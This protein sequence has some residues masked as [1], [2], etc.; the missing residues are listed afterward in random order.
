[1]QPRRFVELGSAVPSAAGD[2]AACVFEME[3]P[4]GTRR[5]RVSGLAP[6]AVMALARMVW[7]EG[8]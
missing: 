8:Q 7:S 6:E 3:G 1:M 2:A 5:L 4:K